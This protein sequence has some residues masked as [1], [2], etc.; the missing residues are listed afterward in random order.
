MAYQT[1]TTG[2]R[3][4]QMLDAVDF[5]D[6]TLRHGGWT[7][8]GTTNT[9]LDVGDSI[10][11]PAP[12]GTQTAMDII[13]TV[14]QA[15][16]GVFYI[17]PDGSAVYEERGSRARRTGPT[18]LYSVTSKALTSNVATLTIT[19]NHLISVG[20]SITV[21][22]VDSTFNGTFTVT[23]VTSTTVSYAVTAA[24]VSATACSGTV[25]IVITSAAT[26]SDPGFQLDKLV[27]RQQVSRLDATAATAGTAIG[28]PQLGQNPTS[29]ALYGVS[30]GSDI[31][32]YCLNSDTA[33]FSLAQYIVNIKSG[34]QAPLVV[35]LDCATTSS[36]AL[37]INLDLQDR[38]TVV[39][40]AIGVSGD[41]I[42]EQIEHT[43]TDAGQQ[44][45]TK[46]TLSPYGTP[47][48]VFGSTTQGVFAPPNQSWTVSNKALTSN[49]ATLTV[50][51]ATTNLSAGQTVIVA[52]VGV[53]F[54]GT[55]MVSTVTST[56]FTYAV[57]NTN[58]ASTSATGTV[59]NLAYSSCVHRAAYRF[60]IRRRGRV[61]LRNRFRQ[62]PKEHGH[63]RLAR[64]DRNRVP[65]VDLLGAPSNAQDIYRVNCHA[66]HGR[67]VHGLGVL[68]GN[69]DAEQ[70]YVTAA[71]A[72]QAFRG[73][74]VHVVRG[75]CMG[76]R[77]LRP[78]R[79]ARQRDAEH[80]PHV[81]HGW[82]LP[83]DVRPDGDVWRHR[84]RA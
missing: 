54:D 41:Y 24:N 76:C 70:P 50:Q 25:A 56:G 13:T 42:V 28:V 33:A 48:F 67:R 3:I 40:S 73:P 84:F 35:T 74:F 82:H 71:G 80:P 47:A 81:C 55:W 51:E 79:N 9:S 15:E 6:S 49:V 31:S 18:P 45:Q 10:T 34:F 17:G 46:Y 78:G 44:W 7:Y 52:G 64:V 36:Q 4:A 19:A 26:T 1:I 58:I 65:A 14:L 59:T 12:D 63:P 77:G 21:A 61:D 43:I 37:Q 23:A 16:M 5:T 66:E 20:S 22:G 62:V 68:L 72:R 30:D 75:D 2:S 57:T 83:G 60:H 11:V 29:I 69:H 27:N 8:L 32:T 53:P 38:V 39:N